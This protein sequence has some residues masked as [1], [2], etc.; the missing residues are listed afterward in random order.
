MGMDLQHC[1]WGPGCLWGNWQTMCA[2]GVVEW[3]RWAGELVVI[4]MSSSED[5]HNLYI[6]RS[7]QCGGAHVIIS[8][9]WS[10]IKRIFTKRPACTRKY[11]WELDLRRCGNSA[12]CRK[13]SMSTPGCLIP[14]GAGQPHFCNLRSMA[15]VQKRIATWTFSTWLSAQVSTFPPF[16]PKIPYWKSTYSSLLTSETYMQGQPLIPSPPTN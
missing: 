6:I 15:E 3:R 5:V 8:S 12:A 14:M 11:S 4:R 10:V 2:C 16:N 13:I 7:L 1:M 9:N